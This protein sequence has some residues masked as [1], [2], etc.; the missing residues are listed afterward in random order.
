MP[1]KTPK[2]QV[3]RQDP[4]YR[5]PEEDR[6]AK[7]AYTRSFEV[8]TAKIKIDLP[9]HKNARTSKKVFYTHLTSPLGISTSLKP[10]NVSVKG[11]SNSR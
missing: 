9:C 11:N 3:A 8:G 10:C 6:D 7:R 5:S 1:E 2:D 4:K